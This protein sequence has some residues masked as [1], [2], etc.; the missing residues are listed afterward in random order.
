MMIRGSWSEGGE[1]AI[2]FWGH[3]IILA[4]VSH[5][6]WKSHKDGGRSTISNLHISLDYGGG[7]PFLY[8]RKTGPGTVQTDNTGTMRHFDFSLSRVILILSLPTH[9]LFL[10]EPYI[11]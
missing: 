8:C 7:H 1:S 2:Q 11:I 3:S 4:H 6:V 10:F 9:I 5:G